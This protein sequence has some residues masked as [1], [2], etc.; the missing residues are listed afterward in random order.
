MDWWKKPGKTGDVPI[1]YIKVPYTNNSELKKV[2]ENITKASGI[3]AKFV[4]T[5]GHSLQN[6]LEKSNPFKGPDCGRVNKCFPCQSGD[7]NNCE[8]RGPAY[9]IS[10]EEPGCKEKGVRYDGESGLSAYS[11]GLAHL[12]GYRNKQANNVLWKHASLEHGGRLDVNYKMKVIRT[13]GKKNMLRK[14]DEANRIT[15][16]LGVRLNSKAEFHQPS[17]SFNF[18]HLKKPDHRRNVATRRVNCYCFYYFDKNLY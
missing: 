13:F 18:C 17:Q 2:M 14:I 10:C 4:E 3:F 8:G 15:G 9:S 12:Q 1:T 6:I 5:S 11:R 7:N 16:N